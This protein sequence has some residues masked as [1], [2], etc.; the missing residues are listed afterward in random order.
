MHKHRWLGLLLAV[1]VTVTAAT[2]PAA[3]GVLTSDHY[4]YIIKGRELA[5]PV[6][7]LTIRGTHL[8][9]EELLRGLGQTPL[10]T[11]ETIRLQRGPV[12]VELT[13]GGLVAQ[14]GGR[15]QVLPVAPM[16]V[17]GRLFVPVAILPSLGLALEVDGRFV[18]L[19]DFAPAEP[20]LPQPAAD[21]YAQTLAE[22]SLRYFMHG[23]GGD[24]AWVRITRLTRDLLASEQMEMDWGTRMRLLTLLETR[25][26]LLVT[27]ENTSDRSIALDPQRWLLTDDRGNQYDYADLEIAVTGKVTAPVAP[28]ATRIAVLG[29]DR[30]EGPLTVYDDAGAVIIG[31]VAG[32]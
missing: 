20:E 31:Q 3:A 29:Y 32:P 13:L 22:H 27:V 6:D 15:Q 18:L 8:V 21:A 26:L 9:P 5:I 17:A 7:I 23:A 1:A 19:Q 14:V 28:G 11:G 10:M 16:V 24:F 12:Q 30:A 4:T 25:T 2:G